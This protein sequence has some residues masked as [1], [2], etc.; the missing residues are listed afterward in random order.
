M[1][2]RWFSETGMGTKVSPTFEYLGE[3]PY[4]IA[5]RSGWPVNFETVTVL[6][7]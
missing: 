1:G 3:F 6:S 7:P 4:Q 2:K 5:V